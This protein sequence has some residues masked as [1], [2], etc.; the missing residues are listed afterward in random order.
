MANYINDELIDFIYKNLDIYQIRFC[1][2]KNTQHAY[3]LKQF[4]HHVSPHYVGHNY[5]LVIKKSKDNNIYVSLIDRMQLKFNKI[6]LK[7]V[8]STIYNLNINKDYYKILESYDNT[9]ID[10]KFITENN[11]KIF[12]IH[13]IFY[14][15]GNKY[16]MNK[17]DEKLKIIESDLVNL[18]NLLNCNFIIKIIELYQYNDMKNLVYDHII[19]TTYN[20]NG[21]MF[22]PLRSGKIILYIDNYEFNNI[23]NNILKI[24][25]NTIISEDTNIFTNPN[26]NISISSNDII[27]INSNDN[28]CKFENLILI[29][30]NIIDVYEVYS[31]DK[32]R[33]HGLACIPTMG[34]SNKLKEYFDNNEYLITKCVYDYK[35]CKW[36][37]ILHI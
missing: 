35:F 8:N 33:R 12:I 28:I 32:T 24:K 19:K 18:N 27:A 15:K 26:N 10:G 17:I 34:L 36:K 20:M 9:I 6:D 5:L 21:L 22:I 2:I 14:Y 13:D 3:V 1:T 16:L 31:I 23:K 29:K 11:N 7:I 30:T 25:K 37:P 4:K